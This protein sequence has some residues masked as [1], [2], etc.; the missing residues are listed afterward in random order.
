[1][2]GLSVLLLVAF[3]SLGAYWFGVRRLGLPAGRLRAAIGLAFETL[4][5]VLVFLMLNVVVGVAVA[6]AA[7]VVSGAFLSVYF[8][9]DARLPLLVL[10]QGL[11]FQCW[12][13][14]GGRRT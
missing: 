3:T 12:R 10:V 8:V 14:S 9:T 6:L 5:V 7:R 2:S 1:M 13:R 4:G 11:A